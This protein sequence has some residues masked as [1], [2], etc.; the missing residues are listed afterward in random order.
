MIVP[1]AIETP[2]LELVP[3]PHAVITGDLSALAHAEGWPHDDTFDALRLSPAV[4]LV[5]L[6]GLVIGECGTAGEIGETGDVEIGYGLAAEYRGLGY[7]A[8]L[9][10]SLSQWLLRAEGVARVVA[11]VE[12]RNVPSRRCLERAGFVVERADGGRVWYALAR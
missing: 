10:A 1:A 2:R 7:G 9:V 11:A 8:E 3:A 4:W 5:S 12:V 6:D